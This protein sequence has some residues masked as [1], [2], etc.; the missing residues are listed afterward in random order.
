MSE[1]RN[2]NR[3]EAVADTPPPPPLGIDDLLERVRAGY[4]RIGPSEAAAAAEAGALLVDIRYAA[5]RDRDGLIPGALVVERNELEWRLDPRGSHR[6]AE[7]VGHDLQV[8]VVCDE[9]YASSLAVASLRQLGLHRAT[10]LTG[11]FQAWRA[12]GLPVTPHLT[13]GT[14]TRDLTPGI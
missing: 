1:D 7:A 4:D 5:L 12:A 2:T 13:P 3:D 6:A 10:D 11:G 8:V 14:D 9:G